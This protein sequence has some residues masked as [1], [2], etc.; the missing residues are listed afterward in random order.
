MQNRFIPKGSS[1][2]GNMKRNEYRKV[3]KFIIDNFSN[4]KQPLDEYL[5]QIM[6]VIVENKS[7]NL[8]EDEYIRDLC[9]GNIETYE[10]FIKM[11]EKGIKVEKGLSKVNLRF[12]CPI[13]YLQQTEFGEKVISST[14]DKYIG[15]LMDVLKVDSNLYL[16]KGEFYENFCSYFL[17]DVGIKNWVTSRSKDE[18]VDIIGKIG[19]NSASLKDLI[20]KSEQYLLV[21]V[22]YHASKVDWSVIRHL[23]G[24]GN[25]YKHEP[26]IIDKQ[27][28]FIG[29]APVS[30]LVISFSGFSERAKQLANKFN[31]EILDGY[32]LVD[33]LCSIGEQ[34][35]MALKFLNENTNINKLLI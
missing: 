20:L 12:D 28:H 30:L 32:N 8:T 2:K 26:F 22:K 29:A 19:R 10:T 31:V 17:E 27:E 13:Y 16:N 4:V 21:Q 18:G 7:I 6:P 5:V 33:V 35:S 34:K 14:K 11:L 24:D 9:G 25:L 23:I 1:A 3:L 15:K